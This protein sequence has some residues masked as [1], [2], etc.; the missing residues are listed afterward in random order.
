MD[1]TPPTFEEFLATVHKAVDGALQNAKQHVSG[2]V[3]HPP[4]QF[5]YIRGDNEP[6]ASAI[7]I[8]GCSFIFITEEMVRLLLH[9][10]QRL[11]S[12]ETIA[13]FNGVPI[14]PDRQDAIYTVM[15]QFQLA[16]I[17][18]HEYTHHVHG[19]TTQP[20]IV[21]QSAASS[22]LQQQAAEI[23]ADGYAVFHVLSHFIIGQGREQAINLLSCDQMETSRQDEILLSLII[24]AL[25]SLLFVTDRVVIEPAEVYNL[26]HPPQAV[27]MDFITRNV[28]R[29]IRLNRTELEA[30]FT[31]NRFRA[32][33][34][35]AAR[36]TWGMNGGQDWDK[37]IVF[38][39]SENGSKYVEKL[40]ELVTT[41]IKS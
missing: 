29:W 8:G 14:T 10:C 18:S 34:M 35:L 5:G 3:A 16:F 22:K 7:S 23:D 28:M 15:F 32:Q 2:H 17:I 38:F 37:Q 39:T 31:L 27:R 21:N 19:H 30:S 4:F 13:E 41:L 11:G 1:D 9:T 20:T 36:A 33:M 26:Q 25:G 12:S 24:M 40:E 6:N